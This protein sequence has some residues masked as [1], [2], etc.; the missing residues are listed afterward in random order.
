EMAVVP[1]ELGQLRHIR[2]DGRDVTE[3]LHVSGVES[4]VSQVARQERV[5]ADL[6]PLQRNL[7]ADGRIIMAGRD[8]GTV[9]LP[10]ADLKLYLERSVA[11]RARRRASERGIAPGSAQWRELEADLRRRDR[12]DSE[13]PVAP[14]RVPDGAVLVGGD[15]HELADTVDEIV[16]AIR[17][18]EAE[19][20]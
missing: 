1:D 4:S 7:A 5:R 16:R 12:I 8:I 15:G 6:L 14:L 10:D 13:R 11:E 17:S 3:Q 18:R 2:V 20:H 19:L 9:V